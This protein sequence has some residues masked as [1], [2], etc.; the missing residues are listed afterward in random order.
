MEVDFR[1]IG[2]A[3]G[4]VPSSGSVTGFYVGGFTCG[5]NAM[6]AIAVR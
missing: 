1:K 3:A 6:N 5:R 2:L 4:S